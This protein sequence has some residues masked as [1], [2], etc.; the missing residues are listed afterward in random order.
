MMAKFFR[1]L[2]SSAPSM[3][4]AAC[5][6]PNAWTAFLHLA[7]LTTFAVTQPVFDRLSE[8]P[9]FLA[10]S[11]LGLAPLLLV[12]VLFSVVIPT[13]VAGTVV[14]TGRL[15]PRLRDPLYAVAVFG[16]LVVILL[17]IVKRIRFLP[18]WVVIL[19]A[20]G[21][22]AAATWSYFRL[23]RCRSLV[24]AAAPAIVIFPTIFLGFSPVRQLFTETIAIPKEAGR[25]VPVVVVVFDEFCGTTLE[26]ERREIDADRF[27][28]FAELAR[29]CTWFR[30]A[31]T[32]SPDTWTAVPAILAGKYP[33]QV[34]SPMPGDLPQNLFSVL[35]AAGGDGSA[36]FEPVSRLALPRHLTATAVAG[37][38]AAER[39]TA[40]IPTLARVFLF[41]L[42]PEDLHQYLPAIPRLWFGLSNS[43]HV[44]RKQRQGLFRYNWGQD[45]NDQFDHF[46]DCLDDSREPVLYFQ[47]ILLPHVPWCYLPSGRRYLAES[48]QFELLNFDTHNQ[49]ADF[50][51]TDDLFVAQSAQRYLLQL[52]YVDRLVGRLLDRLRATG[53]FDKCLLVVTA[54]HGICFR[55]GQFRRVP[56]AGNLADIL[57]IPLFVKLPGQNAGA[58]SDRNVEN[59]DILPTISEVLGIEMH[60]P[61]DGQS[62]VDAAAPERNEK[63]YYASGQLSTVRPS[64]LNAARSTGEIH[65]RFGS[66]LD[67]QAF[68]RV[69]PSPDLVGRSVETLPASPGPPV[70]IELTRG[71]TLYSSDPQDLVPCYLQGRVRS[72]AGFEEPIRFAVAINGTIRAV[73]RTYLLDGVRDRWSAIVP[74]AAYHEGENDVQYFAI[75]GAP[76]DLRLRP[77]LVKRGP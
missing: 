71:G 5:S 19:L 41:H 39:A 32:V 35:E 76:P 23:R 44:N 49:V 46:L 48:N 25:H 42:L 6:A 38:S 53:L 73:T 2:A 52:E 57:S 61:V 24:T 30:N 34:N 13:I 47:H 50:W 70:E 7:V 18:A 72:A 4:R 64:I 45:R 65:S 22:A 40:I 43:E 69:G 17:P 75:D 8:R 9:A 63:K 11:G 1:R 15:F 60:L 26:N 56:D 37:K 54:D 27:P 68:Y 58:I 14:L 21:L 77:C 55:T 12:T 66:A 51:G 59:I 62:L 16:L 33:T 31:T 3:P 36:I 20:L 29:S 28:H 74:E 10:D 67:G